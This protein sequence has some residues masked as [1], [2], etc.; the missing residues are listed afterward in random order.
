MAGL[1]FEPRSGQPP[2]T[3]PTGSEHQNIISSASPLPS[4]WLKPGLQ[5]PNACCQRLLWPLINLEN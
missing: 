3:T 5:T 4:L 1:G 2:D